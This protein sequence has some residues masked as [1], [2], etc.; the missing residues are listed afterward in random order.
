MQMRQR[1]WRRQQQL[2][3][4]SVRVLPRRPK[5]TAEGE[6]DAAN[7]RATDADA[8]AALAKTAETDADQRATDAD[9]AAALAKTAETDADQRATAAE[10]ER[11]TANMRAET[12]EA[13]LKAAQD[14]LD[15]ANARIVEIEE[16]AGDA[17]TA[18]ALA[19]R[20]ARER[21]IQAAIRTS[22]PFPTGVEAVTATRNAA[23]MVAV[24]V[25]DDDYTGGET[26]AGS[27]DWNSATLT[28][29]INTLVIY[30]DVEA[31]ADKKFTDKYE[32]TEL[33]DALATLRVAKVVSN[34]FPSAPDTSWTYTGEDDARATTVTGTFDGVP[35]DFTCAAPPC[36]VMTDD[37][38]KLMGVDGWRFTADSQNTATVKDEL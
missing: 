36:T 34:G 21:M 32:Q 4:G 35:G 33:D 17:L 23:G 20:I 24:K 37:E 25:D 27:G 30:T 2:K 22:D 1:H 6:R 28:N 11:D 29:G 5:Q 18:K 16:L 19:D 13:D 15:V 3:P 12:A 7:M 14:D 8:A 31:P 10:G 9:A 26:T 38:G